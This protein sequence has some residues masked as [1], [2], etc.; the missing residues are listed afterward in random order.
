VLYPREEIVR[1]EADTEE[2]DTFYSTWVSNDAETGL[3]SHFL[4]SDKLE[5]RFFST[6]LQ[7]FLPSN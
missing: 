6:Y 4:N 7:F 5:D 1:D 2:I 3:R